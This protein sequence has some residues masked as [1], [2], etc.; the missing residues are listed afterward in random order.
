MI[1]ITGNPEAILKQET[2]YGLTCLVLAQPMGH[3]CGYVEI[4]LGH[5]LYNSNCFD[6]HFPSLDVHGGVTYS[7]TI[8]IIGKDIYTLGF[9]AAHAGDKGDPS[10][11][12]EK[13]FRHY[14][15]TK[16]V[17]S[18]YGEIKSTE[19]MMKEC[20]GLAKQIASMDLKDGPR[21]SI[22]LEEVLGYNPYYEKEVETMGKTKRL[23]AGRDKLS[24]LDI[25]EFDSNEVS[26]MD[27]VWIL[28]KPHF[29]IRRQVVQ[30]AIFCAEQVIHLWVKKYP[31]DDRPQKAIE[32]AKVC[33]D[34][35]SEENKGKADDAASAAFAS[36]T[37]SAYDYNP[38]AVSAAYAASSSA[39]CN[40]S[41]TN[42]V[43]AATNAA[44][45]DDA[46]AAT[47][48]AQLEFLKLVLM[49]GES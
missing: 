2:H 41:A 36:G 29:L 22:T 49:E 48:K 42:A 31:K 7:G 20:K 44:F 46:Y 5:E 28:T 32:V 4:P 6:E 3:R 15:E 47:R 35:P 10:I 39:S 33:L 8:R 45:A 14:S 9:D 40:A 16:Y 27:K 24:V 18:D 1:D 23:F 34:N 25:L 19:Y 26:D 38:A 43:R 11:M 30:F 17:F 12:D 21:K 37:D 13:H